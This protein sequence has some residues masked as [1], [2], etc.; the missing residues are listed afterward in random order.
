MINVDFKTYNYWDKSKSGLEE[1][2]IAAVKP[3]DL[4]NWLQEPGSNLQGG[5]CISVMGE[6]WNGYWDE[7][8]KTFLYYIDH[9]D[10]AMRFLETLNYFNSPH[11]KIGERKGDIWQCDGST[12]ELSLIGPDMILLIDEVFECEEM[13]TS[14]TFLS[15]VFQKAT[16]DL[17]TCLQE[18]HKLCTPNDAFKNDIERYIEQMEK[19]ALV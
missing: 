17:K 4:Y 9:I 16:K 2:S 8:K 12:L 7:D 6:A 18:L 19:Y 3:Q 10:G 1:I 5:F 15:F 14:L 13:V 11:A